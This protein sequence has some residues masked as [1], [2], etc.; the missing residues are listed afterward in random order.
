MVLV[1]FSERGEMTLVFFSERREKVLDR[2][3]LQKAPRLESSWQLVIGG[4]EE[5]SHPIVR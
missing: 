2:V 5:K 4:G 1:L 3:I